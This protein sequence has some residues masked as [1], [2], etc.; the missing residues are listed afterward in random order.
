MD[1]LEL[2]NKIDSLKIESNENIS[3]FMDLRGLL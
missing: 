1:F 2:D 3:E